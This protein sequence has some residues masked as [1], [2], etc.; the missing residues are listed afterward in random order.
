MAGT[1]NPASKYSD[2]Q[3]LNVL[4]QLATGVQYKNI[5]ASTNVSISTIR[6]I[7]NQ[8]AH[9]YLQEKYPELYAAMLA[10]GANE[11]RK[12]HSCGAASRGITYPPII[13]PEGK[14]YIVTHVANFAREHG[15]DASCLAKVLKRTPKYNTHKGWELKT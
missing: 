1:K 12:S 10:H 4:Q 13:S 8:E 15:L 9:A 2:E 6:H 11:G 5:H 7:A 3:I 14:E